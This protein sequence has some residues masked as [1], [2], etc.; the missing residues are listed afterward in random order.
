MQVFIS[1]AAKDRE[2]ATR[3]ALQLSR[4]GFPVW[5]AAEDIAPGDN[6]A[7]KMGEALEGSDVMVALITPG[8]LE[9]ESL[10]GDIQ[11]GL[12]SKKFEQRLV[13]VLVGFVTFAGGKDVPW[14]LL[15]MDPVYVESPTGDFEPVIQRITAVV[16]QEAQQTNAAH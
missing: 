9:S 12:T 5:Y 13:P 14:I 15:K 3:L 1:H 8:A 10:R 16:G 2:L 4:A 11:Y 6:W 7:K